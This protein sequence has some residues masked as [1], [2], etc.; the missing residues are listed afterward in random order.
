MVAAREAR[1]A[2]DAADAEVLRCVISHVT[3]EEGAAAATAAGLDD[4]VFA[5]GVVCE[6][7]NH[8]TSA[9]CFNTCV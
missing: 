4:P 7:D 9:L 3:K 6:A 5:A 8:Y 1:A 2:K